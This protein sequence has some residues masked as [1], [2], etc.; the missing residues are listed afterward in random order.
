MILKQYVNANQ[1]TG[2]KMRN[3]VGWYPTRAD[4]VGARVRI[5]P[6]VRPADHSK[7]W[8]TQNDNGVPCASRTN[9]T[10]LATAH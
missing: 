5:C 9:N 6:R 10:V 8:S 4:T 7:L 3:W 1:I 2:Q